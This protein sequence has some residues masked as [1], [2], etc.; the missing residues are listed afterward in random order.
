MIVIPAIRSHVVAIDQCPILAT[1]L[2]IYQ[3]IVDE[4]N[5]FQLLSDRL[6]VGRIT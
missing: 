2:E 1:C 6:K 4:I 5:Q 3:A